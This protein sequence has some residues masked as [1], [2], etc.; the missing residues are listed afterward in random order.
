MQNSSI[1]AK[2][3]GRK[4]KMTIKDLDMRQRA[5]IGASEDL[6]EEELVSVSGGLR[7]GTFDEPV[8]GVNVPPYSRHTRMA[9]TPTSPL[10]QR[11]HY[12]PR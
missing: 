2:K 7:F 6:S 1:A 11:S 10:S 4:K 8:I 9:G 5:I 12:L 3:K